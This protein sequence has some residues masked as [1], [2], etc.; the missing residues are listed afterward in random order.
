MS[1]EVSDT[2]AGVSN[3]EAAK[4]AEEMK[5]LTTFTAVLAASAAA[6]S[7]ALADDHARD[8]QDRIDRYAPVVPI[9]PETTWG[10][11]APET[12]FGQ[13]TWP[14]NPHSLPTPAAVVPADDGGSD[15]NAWLL[16]GVGLVTAGLV[17]G[18]A[19]GITRRRRVR[20]RRVAV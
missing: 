12:P 6:A 7:P 16:V 9:V 17:G 11:P 19:A 3:E 14:V 18:S 1:P 13:P 15:D 4:G 5:R 20:A 2:A 10:T 8:A